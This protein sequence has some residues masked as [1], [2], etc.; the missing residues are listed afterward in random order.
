MKIRQG[1]V[2]NSSS[3]SFVIYGVSVDKRDSADYLAKLKAFLMETGDWELEEGE[4]ANTP[5]SWSDIAEVLEEYRG[6]TVHTDWDY[7][8]MYIGRD[9]L[10]CP[11]DMTMG[12]FKKETVEQLKLAFGG[13]LPG[14]P[15]IEEVTTNN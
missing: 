6:L 4:D 12:Q 15:R 9:P 13:T 2:S 10:T 14:T 5:A 3:S 11:D 7:G 1:F 8:V